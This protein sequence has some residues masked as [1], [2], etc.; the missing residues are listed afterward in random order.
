MSDLT[1]SCADSSVAFIRESYCHIDS[2][3]QL[4][5][6]LHAILTDI[7][8][9]LH[10]KNINRFG[11]PCSYT[12]CSGAHVSETGTCSIY[13]TNHNFPDRKL[14]AIRQVDDIT[15]HCFHPGPTFLSITWVREKYESA[16]SNTN[17]QQLFPHRHSFYL[18]K[19]D[20][21]LALLLQGYVVKWKA[22]TPHL[23]VLD[24]YEESFS[25]KVPVFSIP[26][27]E[28]KLKELALS[29]KFDFT[30][31]T[32]QQ[33]HELVTKLKQTNMRACK[34]AH[35]SIFELKWRCQAYEICNVESEDV[36]FLALLK[37]GMPCKVFKNKP[38]FY[39]TFPRKR[40]LQ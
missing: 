31:L 30:H 6:L 7:K 9:K 24:R 39:V 1:Y 25:F 35:H 34:S 22:G 36:L 40:K 33:V 12:Y 26:V 32:D 28:K 10:A 2:D 13:C 15:R 29:S 3:E 16:V 23:N 11:E 27:V 18:D 20:L 21:L 4:Q 37:M 19:L 8:L 5:Q 17:K 38:E 14:E